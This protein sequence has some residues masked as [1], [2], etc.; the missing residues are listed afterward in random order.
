MAEKVSV[1][2]YMNNGVMQ[3]IKVFKDQDKAQAYYQKLIQ[4]CYP[5]DADDIINGEQGQE[6]DDTIDLYVV[7]VTE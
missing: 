1:V 6:G 5:D 2:S 4:D 3:E 7:D